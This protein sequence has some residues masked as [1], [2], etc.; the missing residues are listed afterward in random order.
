M[1]TAQ[2]QGTESSHSRNLRVLATRNFL[3]GLRMNM[4]RA[5]W[6]PFVLHLGA[7]MSLLGLLEAIG[8]F[9]GIVSTATLPL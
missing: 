4:M 5:V 2:P 7:S 1:S 9:G 8:G 6:Q 3:Y